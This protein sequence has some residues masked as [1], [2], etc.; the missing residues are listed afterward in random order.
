MSL[1]YADL[2]AF[3]NYTISELVPDIQDERYRG[4]RKQELWDT[5]LGIVRGHESNGATPGESLKI[6]LELLPAH[7]ARAI[8]KD[9]RDLPNPWPSNPVPPGFLPIG[10]EDSISAQDIVTFFAPDMSP[11]EQAK[12]IAAIEAGEA[13]PVDFAASIVL[14]SAEGGTL[15]AEAVLDHATSNGLVP[16]LPADPAQEFAVGLYIA[17]FGRAGEHDGVEYWMDVLN[18]KIAGGLDTGAALQ[19]LAGDMYYAGWLNGEGGTDIVDTTAY[20]EFVYQNVLGRAPDA[21]GLEYWVQEIQSGAIPREKF[22]ADFLYSA[23]QAQGDSAYLEARIDVATYVA[24]ESV[25]GPGKSIDLAGVLV[26][27]KDA[28]S[29]DARIEA[30]AAG[31]FSIKAGLA[32]MSASLDLTDLN[33]DLALLLESWEVPADDAYS[34][35]WSDEQPAQDIVL[36]GDVGLEGEWLA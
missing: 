26:D 18:A 21:G 32:A 6:I 13:A 35:S 2:T 36:L 1:T 19:S 34:S 12:L 23:L 11:A 25:S 33:D 8:A 10:W 29:A 30:I 28:A 22:L 5:W 16:D 17:A 27:V 14:V 31:E 9:D 7:I 15:T 20:V 3:L 4:D 24:R